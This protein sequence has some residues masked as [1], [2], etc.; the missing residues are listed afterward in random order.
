[1]AKIRWIWTSWYR[2]ATILDGNGC[3]SVLPTG[4][5]PTAH[6][7]RGSVT[8]PALCQLDE[9]LKCAPSPSPYPYRL[10][11]GTVQ[12]SPHHPGSLIV[13]SSLMYPH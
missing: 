5:G 7:R 2:L 1:M 3:G 9:A 4:Q 12:G 11:P 10:Q 13:T 8:G 6:Y